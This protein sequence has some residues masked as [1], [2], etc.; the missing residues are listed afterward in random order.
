MKTVTLITIEDI[1]KAIGIK[2]KAWQGNCYAIARAIVRAHLVEGRS[3]YGLYMG[4]VSS[5]G[6]YKG[7]AKRGFHRHGW[8]R[9]EDGR[10]MD[11]TRWS[12]ENQPPYVYVIREPE[13][14]AEECHCGH[15]RDEHKDGFFNSC[16]VC[17][18]PDYSQRER[19]YDEAAQTLAEM[20]HP[21]EMPAFDTESKIK[22]K[23]ALSRKAQD[24]IKRLGGESLGA[25][26]TG[27]Q[28][29]WIANTPVRQ[30]ESHAK[31]I[32]EWLVAKDARALIPVDNR[33]MVLGEDICS[34]P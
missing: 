21:K 10:I 1:E 16:L 12:F 22:F 19:E 14:D 26:V 33:A 7:R 31:E 23:V 17:D 28:A 3:V 27:E 5:R 4:P 9:L 15:V 18:C 25:R 24:H 11:P 20:M 8:I 34:T 30:L 2:T 6:Y 13:P 32:Y 29:H